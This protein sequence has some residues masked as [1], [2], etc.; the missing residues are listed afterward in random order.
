MY[1]GNSQEDKKLNSMLH[2]NRAAVA[3]RLKEHDKA[4]DDCRRAIKLDPTNVKAYF[5]A[6]RS[7]ELL[8]LT[9]QA[10]SFC[11]SALKLVPDDP[12]VKHLHERLQKSLAKEEEKLLLLNRQHESGERLMQKCLLFWTSV[13]AG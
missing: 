10:L 13:V 12:D 8:T 7:S 9:K 1:D 4:V 11:E 5:R 2:S 3:M 6:A